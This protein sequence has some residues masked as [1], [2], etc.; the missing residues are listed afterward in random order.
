MYF[1]KEGNLTSGNYA[2]YFQLDKKVFGNHNTSVK[3]GWEVEK[4]D[5]MILPSSSIMREEMQMVAEGKIEEADKYD[6]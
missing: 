3:T 5:P 6:R 2:K 1:A 4:K